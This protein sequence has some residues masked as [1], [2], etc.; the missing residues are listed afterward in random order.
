MLITV[1]SCR[2]DAYHD[3]RAPGATS[4][5]PRRAPNALKVFHELAVGIKDAYEAGGCT[6]VKPPP[7]GVPGAVI[8]GGEENEGGGGGENDENGNSETLVLSDLEWEGQRIL[9]DFMGNLDF[10]STTCH[11]MPSLCFVSIHIF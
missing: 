2:S 6:P 10:V 11:I 3:Q 5:L 8:V 9:F 1:T 4:K 7:R